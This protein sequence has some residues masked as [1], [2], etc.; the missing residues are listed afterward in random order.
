MVLRP[1][2][3]RAMVSLHHRNEMLVWEL[4]CVTYTWGIIL[5]INSTLAE[6]THRDNGDPPPA[7]GHWHIFFVFYCFLTKK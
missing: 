7:A 1:T 4:S 5:S 2:P 6:A 3:K